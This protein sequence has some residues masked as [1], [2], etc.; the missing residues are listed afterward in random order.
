M[1]E[2]TEPTPDAGRQQRIATVLR[3]AVYV[4]DEDCDAPDDDACHATHP[5][6]AAVLHHGIVTDLYGPID[7]L[8]A[9]LAPLVAKERTDGHAACYGCEPCG[10]HW[11]GRT[12]SEVVPMRDGQPVCPRCELN[13]LTTTEEPRP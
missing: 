1:T 10:F 9:V 7:A 5:I 4:C 8:A 13:R 6:Q 11:H 2:P 12:P 3:E